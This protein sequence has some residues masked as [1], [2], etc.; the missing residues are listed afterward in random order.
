MKKL[1][2]VYNPRSSHYVRVKAEVLDVARKLAGW[3]VG[4][5]EI[6]P[7]KIRDNAE[8]L[9]QLLGDGDLVIAVGGDGT[10][11]IAVNAVMRSGRRVTLGVL[12]Y[13][14]FNDMA[15]AFGIERP[16]EY[17]DEFLGGITE[18]VKRFETNDVERVW[19]L[20]V[21]VDDEHWRYA[22][23]YVTCGMLA[24]STVVFDEREVRE[25]LRTGRR[26]LLFSW[27]ASVGWYFR[28]RK[29]H[30]PLPTMKLNGVEVLDGTTDYIAMNSDRMARLMKGERWYL[31]KVSFASATFNIRGLG[32]VLKL[33]IRSL[34]KTPVVE[35]RG[36]VLELDNPDDI[37]IQV[38]GEYQKLEGVTKVEVKKA[39]VPL[40]V[41]RK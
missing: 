22:M 3:M 40:R 33:M 27:L 12:G 11:S 10:A 31:E 34:W 16:V 15:M 19:P 24:A 1:V 28:N 37:E 39:E 9:A 20:E 18:I 2:L 30:S 41:V 5:Y 25:Q 38:E 36:D 13:G 29:K 26:G 23:C 6:K 21:K 17:G 7:T 4:K 14:N 32:G 8:T 35:T